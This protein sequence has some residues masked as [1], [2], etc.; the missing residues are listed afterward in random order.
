MRRPIVIVA[1][2]SVNR[3]AIVGADGVA[4]CTI[5]LEFGSQGQGECWRSADEK[6][7]GI[8]AAI[9]GVAQK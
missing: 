1:Q 8:C 6:A 5:L 4:A 3:G 2:V 7:D 9:S